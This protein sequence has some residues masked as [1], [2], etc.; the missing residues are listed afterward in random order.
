[1]KKFLI[2]AISLLAFS[3]TS[4]AATEENPDMMDSGDG[5]NGKYNMQYQK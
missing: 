1:M 4:C 2:L 5:D 3:L